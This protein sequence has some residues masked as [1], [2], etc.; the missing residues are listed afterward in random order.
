VL[1]KRLDDNARAH[2]NT[3]DF[4]RTSCLEALRAMGDFLFDR[5][6][7]GQLIAPLSWLIRALDEVEE[8]RLPELFD[9][10]MDKKM[11]EG[12]AKW[13]RSPAA[14]EIRL[15]AA[16]LMD[17]LMSEGMPRTQA[18]SKVTEAMSNWPR[19]DSGM[20]KPNTVGNWRDEFLQSAASDPV[21]LEYE[22]M[23]NDFTE[24]PRAKEYREEVLRNGPPLTGGR[25][26]PTS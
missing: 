7:A 10:K 6:A 22:M 8:G 3:D 1:F 26:H 13:S 24:G 16:A 5:G 12:R 25:R 19:P 11:S 18:L 14:M 20:L 23:V 17:A 15:Y 9:P 4:G 2:E 21:R